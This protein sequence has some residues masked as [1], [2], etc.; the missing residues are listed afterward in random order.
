MYGF[1]SVS[2]GDL[3]EGTLY[4]GL[5]YGENE[6]RWG[7]IRKVYGILSAQILL[8]TLVSSLTVLYTPLNNLL[9][10]SSGLL[11]LFAILPLI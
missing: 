11:F 6:L 2:K 7:F 9:Q 3:E 1:T 10:G 4:P 8:T 5:S